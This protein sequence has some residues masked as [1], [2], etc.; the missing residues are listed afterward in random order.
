MRQI[1]FLRAFGVGLI[2]LWAIGCGGDSG[3]PRFATDGTVL[4]DGVPLPAGVIRFI[5][6]GTTKGPAASALIETGKFSLEAS[7]GP[8]AGQHRVEIEATGHEG[9]AVDDEQAY[10]QKATTTRGPVIPQNPVPAIYNRQ[11]T[12]SKTITAEGPNTFEF[13]LSSKTQTASR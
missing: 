4:L 11:S 7:N 2:A 8:V 1:S 5:P 9:F 12:L 10:A 13:T 6:E 3:P